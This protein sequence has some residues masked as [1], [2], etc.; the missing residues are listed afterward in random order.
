VKEVIPHMNP[1]SDEQY[2]SVFL[3]NRNIAFATQIATML[4]GKVCN[5]AAANGSPRYFVPI[6]TLSKRFAV[7]Q[8]IRT[9]DDLYGGVVQHPLHGHKGALH[10]LVP[11]GHA[12]APYS[13]RFAQMV[14]PAVLPGF[15]AFSPEDAVRAFAEL[16][17]QG[18]VV[19]HKD[20]RRTNCRGQTI[21]ESPCHAKL[22]A[23]QL[24]ES[25]AH[26]GSVLEV[27]LHNPETF[28]VGLLH[29]D[30]KPYS[31]IGDQ[32]TAKDS[33][34]AEMYAGTTLRMVRGDLGKLAQAPGLDETKKRGIIQAKIVSE[35]Y[36]NLGVMSSRMVLDVI[37]G[38]S[39]DSNVGLS[40]VA[41]PAL[42]PGG[43][44]PAEL[45]AIE[46]LRADSS[47]SEVSTRVDVYF[48]VPPKS[49][50]G[51]KSLFFVGEGRYITAE[52]L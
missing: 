36:S 11:G 46:K 25:L 2:R 15:T 1:N 40:G 6:N 21:V 19:R 20:P 5:L 14:A 42:R 39:G 50:I 9:P 33:T 51:H 44:S 48:G 16:G 31:F 13:R 30:G 37:Q 3:H 29:F 23:E 12:P 49:L 35:A 34:D 8:S 26:H 10:K 47:I 7:A 17:G 18:H 22:L 38:T 43:A 4:G 24:G 27:N 32:R 52:V 45:L 28:N 41:D